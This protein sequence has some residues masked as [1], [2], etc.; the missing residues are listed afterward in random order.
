MGVVVIIIVAAAATA[1]ILLSLPHGLPSIVIFR[2]LPAHLLAKAAAWAVVVKR[3][4]R[5][6]PD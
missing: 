3:S 6:T 2:N 4:S 5:S 1:P